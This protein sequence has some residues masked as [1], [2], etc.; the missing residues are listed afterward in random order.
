[1]TRIVV[2][3]T[4]DFF[5]QMIFLRLL[6]NSDDIGLSVF[7]FHDWPARPYNGGALY[8]G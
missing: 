7:N 8:A 6:N 1:M 2:L 4:Y 5:A 3:I